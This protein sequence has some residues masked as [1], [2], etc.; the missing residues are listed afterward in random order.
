MSLV[1]YLPAT[2]APAEH[3]ANGLPVGIQ[4]IGPYLEDLNPIQFAIALERE[5]IGPYQLPAGFE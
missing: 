1:A 2:V 5:I 4:T 3:T